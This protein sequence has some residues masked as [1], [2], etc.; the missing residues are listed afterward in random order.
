MTGY[1]VPAAIR[2]E[3]NPA[4]LGTVPFEFAAGVVEPKDETEAAVLA[5]AATNG[6]VEPVA[7][8][9]A[10]KPKAAKPETPSEDKE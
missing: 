4:D 10:Q 7:A 6:L 8:K 1:K 2:G 3:V 5:W 9:P